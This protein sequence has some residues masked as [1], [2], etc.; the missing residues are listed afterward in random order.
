M[1]APLAGRRAVVT[2][3][4]KGTGAAVVRRLKRDGAAVTVVARFVP[5]EMLADVFVAADITKPEGVQAIAVEVQNQGGADII[6]HVAGGSTAPGG[7]YAA[8]T[9]EDWLAELQLNL[10]GAG[11]LDRALITAMV[12]A[13]A[14]A[15][16]HVGS[17]QS[18]MPLY[19]GT[20]GYAA[21]KAALRAYSKGLS[22]ELA[23]K[24]I[25]INTLS[26]GFIA[27]SAAEH[28]I[29]RIAESSGRDLL[30]SRDQLRKVL[31]RVSAYGV[32]VVRIENVAT[33][34]GQR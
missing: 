23:P 21:A 31:L 16:V 24:G 30:R 15:I 34:L 14:G 11:R 19:D 27:T 22:N 26:P 1:S 5:D 29:D 7:G 4:S 12:A 10:L 20:L 2:G 13:G 8:L 17:I 18:R 9:D 28:L 3:G 33:D 6:V 25:R 32:R